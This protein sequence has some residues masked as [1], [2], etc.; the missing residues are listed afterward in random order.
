MCH[1]RFLLIQ[2][3]SNRNRLYRVRHRMPP[4]ASA[5]TPY[6]WA[7]T[8]SLIFTLISILMW[9]I[10]WNICIPSKYLESLP[11]SSS[12]H[13]GACGHTS[14]QWN[15]EDDQKLYGYQEQSSVD[16]FWDWGLLA[17]G[18]VPTKQARCAV[19][20][21]HNSQINSV[22]RIHLRWTSLLRSRVTNIVHMTNWREQWIF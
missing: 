18:C 7:N 17:Q 22:C 13:A 20:V 19:L 4:Y 16:N 14:L 8:T 1:S 5:Y 21:G 3:Q 9:I 12:S 6:A 2:S 10:T 15:M 11:S